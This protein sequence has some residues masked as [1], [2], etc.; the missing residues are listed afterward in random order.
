MQKEERLEVCLTRRHAELCGVFARVARLEMILLLGEG[1]RTVHSTIAREKSSSALDEG[2]P[3]P[4]AN[5]LAGKVVPGAGLEGG[6]I[7]H[8]P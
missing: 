8:F 5:T 7:S 1:E 4:S 6:P 2:P 3:F